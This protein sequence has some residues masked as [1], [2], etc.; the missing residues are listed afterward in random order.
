M[1]T[2]GQI[3]HERARSLL[4]LIDGLQIENDLSSSRR[5]VDDWRTEMFSLINNI[6][7]NTINKLDSLT[8]RLHQL[9]Q[10]RSAILRQDIL[11]NLSKMVIERRKNLSEQE[12]NDIKKKITKID[13]DLQAFGR[14][15]NKVSSDEKKLVEQIEILKNIQRENT[16]LSILD[17]ISTP[18]RCFILDTCHS[19]FI[20]VSEDNR[21]LIEDDN[22]LVLFDE[23][24]RINEI[25]WQGHQD[26]SFSGSIKDIIFSNYL[27]QFC[28]LS[29]LHFFTLDPHMLTLEKSEQLKPST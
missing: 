12:L 16:Q 23:Q 17:N 28:V 22:H 26:D 20:A 10:R 11:P 4:T 15:L 2:S 27:E 5:T 13:C 21:M 25:P 3:L 18:K 8:N 6:H 9:K 7:L 1:S 14:L 24:R 19:P 29:A